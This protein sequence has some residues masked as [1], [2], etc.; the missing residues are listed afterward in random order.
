MAGSK[1]GPVVAVEI[2]VE[3]EAVAPLRILLELLGPSVYRTSSIVAP[4]EDVRQS[5]ADLLGDLV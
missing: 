1:P 5:L 2:L 4:Q 3:Q